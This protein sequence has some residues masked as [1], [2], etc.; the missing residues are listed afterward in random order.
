MLLAQS[1]RSCNPALGFH[2]SVVETDMLPIVVSQVAGLERHVHPVHACCRTFLSTREIGSCDTSCSRSH[3]RAT[4]D[5][6]HVNLPDVSKLVIF[7]RVSAME[8]HAR[9]RV[10]WQGDAPPPRPA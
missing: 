5:R 10:V 1:L 9:R 8:K 7:Y 3:E 6:C 4:I 2:P